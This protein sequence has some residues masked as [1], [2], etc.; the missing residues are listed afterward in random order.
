MLPRMPQVAMT[1]QPVIWSPDLDRAEPWKCTGTAQGTGLLVGA[2]VTT[3]GK[4][5]EKITEEKSQAAASKVQLWP[6]EAE[7]R[8]QAYG[9]VSA[10]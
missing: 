5:N 7:S 4:I 2:L 8:N 1:G 3:S 10:V 9:Q 6:E